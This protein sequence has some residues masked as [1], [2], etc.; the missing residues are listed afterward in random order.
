[1]YRGIMT[2]RNAP[3]PTVDP[4]LFRDAAIHDETRN[5]NRLVEAALAGL[6]ATHTRPPAETR[7]ERESGQ[8]PLP[9]E[10]LPDAS[11]RQI[12]GPAGPITLRQF[13]PS[14]PP[15]SAFLHFHGGGWV[16]GGAHHQDRLLKDIADTCNAAVVSVEYRLA[17]E[18]PYPAGPDDCEAAAC[19]LVENAQDEF[20]TATLAIGGESAGAH[21]SAATLLRM[22]DRHGDTGFAAANLVFGCYDLRL[23]PSVRRWGERNLVL[24]TPMIEWFV[25]QF[26]PDRALRSDPDVSPLAADLSGLPPA[27]F[28]VG[29]LDPLVDDSLFMLGR[30]VAAGNEAELHV[31]PGGIHGFTAFPN[32]P[33][34]EA[35]ERMLE[36]LSQRLDVSA[37]A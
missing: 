13:M 3:L 35:V 2:M 37:A 28:T 18:H 4:A 8:G 20:G 7:A 10:I 29:T 25:E 27:L 31:C 23:T 17:P 11:E 19:W 9:L 5:L 16:L 34:R 12:P 15:R 21:L 36:F 6:P 33:G 14:E 32:K 30:W 24:N 22:R 1:M 26:V